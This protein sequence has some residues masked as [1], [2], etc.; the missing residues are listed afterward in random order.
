VLALDK[1]RALQ[2]V[3]LDALEA[4]KL[5]PSMPDEQKMASWH[6]VA[7][8]GRVWS[9]GDAFAPLAEALG[10]PRARRLLERLGPALNA[11]YRL[12]ADNRNVWGKLVTDGAKRR[13]DELITERTQLS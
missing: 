6:L 11:G 9:A 4:D 8:D 13:A 12:V 2:P 3:A 1:R 5:L 10:Y 7:P